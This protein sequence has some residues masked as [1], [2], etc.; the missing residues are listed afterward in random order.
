MKSPEK[1]KIEREESRKLKYITLL[2]RVA[3]GFMLFIKGVIFIRNDGVLRRVF[4]EVELVQSL[5]FLEFVI[6]WIHI[7]GGFF[8]LIGVFTRL[9]TLI[10]IPL[11]I[12]A[13]YILL[14]A[15]Q[16]PFFNTEIIF[17]GSILVLLV[18]YVVFGDGFY[19]WRH[20]IRK[21]KDVS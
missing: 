16:Y 21:E 5:S 1:S 6:P 3:L 19:S 4:S 2:F 13:L 9:M 18:V 10:Q 14:N 20:L 17:A 8:I 11:I 7:L 15:R 12:G